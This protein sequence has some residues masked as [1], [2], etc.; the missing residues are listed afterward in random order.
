MVNVRLTEE[1]YEWLTALAGDAGLTLSDW[2]RQ[3][4]RKAFKALKK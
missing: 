2:L 1:E 4:I 3:A